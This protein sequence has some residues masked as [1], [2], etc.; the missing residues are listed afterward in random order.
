MNCRDF[1]TEFEE[2]ERLTKAATRH[3]NDCP[4]CKKTSSEQTRVWQMIDILP[5]VDAPV[6]F[7]FRVKARIANSKSADFQSRFFPVLRYVMPLGV[8]VL[9]LGI[10]AFNANYFSDNNDATPQIAK[11]VPPTSIENETTAS[12]PSFTNQNILSTFGNESSVASQLNTNTVSI[13]DIREA[14]IAAVNSKKKRRT[15]TPKKNAE[16]SDGIGSR[17]I[18]VSAPTVTLPRGLD[19]NRRIETAPNADDTKFFTAEEILPFL[20]IEIVLQNENRTVKSVKRNSLAERSGVEVG[21]V[22]EAIDGKQIS[23]EPFSGRTIKVKTLTVLRGV[24]KFEIALH[25]Q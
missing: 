17:D 10:I 9:L 3:L 2:S 20:G 22:I 8:I 1:L 12:D 16:E 19:P 25:N 6:N 14:Q 18:T 11:F 23:D 4:N 7:D 21:D 13:K 15:E 5:R 24:K